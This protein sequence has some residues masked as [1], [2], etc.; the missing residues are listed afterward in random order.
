MRY[1]KSS[2]LALTTMVLLLAS[3]CSNHSGNEKGTTLGRAEYAK[4]FRYTE[5]DHYTLLDI[6][7]PW[8]SSAFLGQF[9]LVEKGFSL[10]SELDKEYKRIN[11]PI[12]SAV[13]SNTTQCEN[14]IRLNGLEIIAAVFEANYIQSAPLKDRISSGEVIDLGESSQMNVEQVIQLNPSLIFTSPYQGQKDNK[15]NTLQTTLLPYLDYMENTPLGQVEWIKVI[16]MLLDKKELADS[17]FAVT[18]GKYHDLRKLC[19]NMEERPT[20][21]GEIKTGST[22]YI[23]SGKSYIANMYKD[24]SA[25]YIFKDITQTGSVPFSEE[26]VFD[27]AYDADFWL[28]KHHHPSDLTLTSLKG[29]EPLYGEFQAYKKGNVYFCN[30]SKRPYYEE[31]SLYPDR[32]L[33]DLIAI[34]HPSLL[35]NHQFYYYQKMAL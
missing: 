20:V 12:E 13:G 24:A 16:G 14:I 7:S 22:W 30:T 9:V 19:E 21:F 28:I 34:F 10:P 35:P 33:A 29:Q 27:Q 2:F 26:K 5:Y 25:D 11:I 31:V 6:V 17:L 8:D 1:Q 4:G 32:L 18:E 3:G 23:S 15:L